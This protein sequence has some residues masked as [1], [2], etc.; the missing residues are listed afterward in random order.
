MLAASFSPPFPP[1]GINP[2]SILCSP[3]IP[4]GPPKPLSCAPSAQHSPWKGLVAACSSLWGS[5]TIWS[6]QLWHLTGWAPNGHP[7]TPLL[8]RF[9]VILAAP[10]AG[11]PRGQLQTEA[12]FSQVVQLCSALCRGALPYS[13]FSAEKFLK[14]L[15]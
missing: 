12:E 15:F 1:G 3:L 14:I 9:H 10:P 8:G 6:P 13:N 7:P 5:G 2:S 4:K 11:S